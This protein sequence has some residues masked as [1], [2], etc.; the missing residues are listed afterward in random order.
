MSTF[1][2][3]G[4]NN[5]IALSSDGMWTIRY[6]STA[7]RIK[8]KANGVDVASI[9]VNGDWRIHGAAAGKQASV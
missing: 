5:E 4:D 8:I 1:L 7:K 3:A 6:D 2:N 9:D